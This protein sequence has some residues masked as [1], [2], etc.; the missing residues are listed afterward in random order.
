MIGSGI[1]LLPAAS[2]RYGLNAI[3]GW[4]ISSIGALC[5]AFALASHAR[6][7]GRR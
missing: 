4:V 1:F 6:A 3:C 7:G 2:R 5:I